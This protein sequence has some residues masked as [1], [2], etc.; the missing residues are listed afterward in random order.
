MEYGG[1]PQGDGDYG[2]VEILLV[3]IDMA[4]QPRA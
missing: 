4:A 3:R 1:V 2:R